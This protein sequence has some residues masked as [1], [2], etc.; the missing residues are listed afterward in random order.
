[1]SFVTGETG[2]KIG[3]LGSGLYDSITK[4]FEIVKKKEGY[5]EYGAVL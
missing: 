1:V 5:E 4:I 2:S 3:E